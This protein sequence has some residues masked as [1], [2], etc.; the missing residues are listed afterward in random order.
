MGFGFH[1]KLHRVESTP[2]ST[3]RLQK[4]METKLALL[5]SKDVFQNP[6]CV[7]FFEMWS[8]RFL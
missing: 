6:E 3:S 8:Y 5:S 2:I 4:I 1:E 7:R